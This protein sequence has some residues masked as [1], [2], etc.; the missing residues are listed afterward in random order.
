MNMIREF[1]CANDF[2]E[3]YLKHQFSKQELWE[4]VIKEAARALGV[5]DQIGTI[6]KGYWADIAIFKYS[7]KGYTS[8]FDPM[9]KGGVEDVRGGRP[10]YSDSELVQSIDS[11]CEVLPGEV[12]GTAKAVCVKETSYGLAD[13]INYNLK[14]Y[15]LFTCE[16]PGDEPTCIPARYE[17]Y[18]GSITEIDIDGDGIEN[19]SDNCPRVFNS[20]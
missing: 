18:S 10:L 11:T 13:L 6:E 20:I 1:S 3:K 8:I 12:C 14:S 15:P 19:S 4:M 2:N 17:E 9:M 7:D 5:N 16:I